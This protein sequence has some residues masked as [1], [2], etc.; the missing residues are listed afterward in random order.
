MATH[1]RE[2]TALYMETT[3]IV[4]SLKV[5]KGYTEWS[6]GLMSSCNE[7]IMKMNKEN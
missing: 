4:N 3:N 7:P 6:E 5:L 1:G 2:L